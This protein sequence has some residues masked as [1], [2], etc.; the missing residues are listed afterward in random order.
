VSEHR[1]LS[2]D[3]DSRSAAH[4]AWLDQRDREQHVTFKPLTFCLVV[5]L[6]DLFAPWRWRVNRLPGPV[7]K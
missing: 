4:F 7:P 3:L 2:D 6:P 1:R 5:P